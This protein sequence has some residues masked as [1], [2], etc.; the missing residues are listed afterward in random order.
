MA[1]VVV[2]AIGFIMWRVGRYLEGKWRRAGATRYSRS[3]PWG[4]HSP[5]GWQPDCYIT[6]A[7]AVYRNGRRC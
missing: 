1:F 4:G 3:P 6:R 5:D 7:G 2:G